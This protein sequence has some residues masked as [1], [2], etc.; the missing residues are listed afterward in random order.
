MYV[1]TYTYVYVRM[2]Q[3]YVQYSATQI[4]IHNKNGQSDYD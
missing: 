3:I 4:S 1:C 2:L